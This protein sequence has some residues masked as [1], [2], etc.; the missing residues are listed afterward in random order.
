MGLRT[1]L[2]RLPGIG[3]FRNAQCLAGVDQCAG[4]LA[5]VLFFA[6]AVGSYILHGALQGTRNQLQ[7]PHASPAWMMTAFMWALVAV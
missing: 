1:F 2:S 3:A 5:S 7:K 6:L 4:G